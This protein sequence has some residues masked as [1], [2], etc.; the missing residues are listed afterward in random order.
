[1]REDYQKNFK[2]DLIFLLHPPLSGEEYE[3]QMGPRTSYQSLLG[4]QN[5]RKIFFS[6]LSPKQF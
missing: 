2:V 4:L 3:K 1:M 6:D 5:I